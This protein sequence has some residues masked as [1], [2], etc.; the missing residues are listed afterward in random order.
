MEIKMKAF[1]YLV[2]FIVLVSGKICFAK[3]DVEIDG[4]K[5]QPLELKKNTA[6]IVN[7]DPDKAMAVITCEPFT[8]E[9]S[10]AV[11]ITRLSPGSCTLVNQNGQVTLISC[12]K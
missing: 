4:Q 11:S 2:L 3:C 1:T 7:R 9:V 12:E 5:L 10:G 8:G 6:T